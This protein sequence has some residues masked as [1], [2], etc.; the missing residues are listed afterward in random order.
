MVR[1]AFHG[2]LRSDAAN[3]GA[4]AHEVARRLETALFKT[5]GATQRYH[6]TGLGKENHFI[7]FG[8]GRNRRYLQNTRGERDGNTVDMREVEIDNEHHPRK[9]LADDDKMLAKRFAR[10]GI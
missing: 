7:K 3:D 6:G 5:S 2:L 1:D 10:G 4:D 9:P 8:V